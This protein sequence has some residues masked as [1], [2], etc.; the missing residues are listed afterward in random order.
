MIFEEIMPDFLSV[1]LREH[2]NINM[3]PERR[4]YRECDLYA[5]YRA[6]VPSNWHHLSYERRIEI[7]K[8]IPITFKL[9]IATDGHTFRW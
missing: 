9:L 3:Y 2:I 4:K 7:F 6:T 1:D 5:R 8:R